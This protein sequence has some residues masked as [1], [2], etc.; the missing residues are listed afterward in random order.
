MC[1]MQEERNNITIFPSLIQDK[2]RLEEMHLLSCTAAKNGV[3]ASDIYELISDKM[4]DFIKLILR[5]GAD[6]SDKMDE[7]A[8]AIGTKVALQRESKTRQRTCLHTKIKDKMFK[9]IEE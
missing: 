8:E 1:D 2:T 6:A 5:G 9:A 7:L 3:R 4:D